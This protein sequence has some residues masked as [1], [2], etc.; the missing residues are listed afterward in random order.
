MPCLLSVISSSMRSSHLLPII[1]RLHLIVLLAASIT[2]TLRADDDTPDSTTN[3]QRPPNIVVIFIDDMGYADIGPFG[4]KDYSTPNLDRMASEGRVFTD[5][6]AATAVCSASRA[7]LLTGC[8]PERIGILG[9]LGPNS[10]HGIN[11]DETTLAEL[12]KS[13][14]YATAIY[15][16][17][18]LGDRP[19]FMPTLHGFD[20]WLGIPYSNDMWPLHPQ[21]AKLSKGAADRKQGYPPLPMY[22]DDHIVDEVITGDEQAQFTKRFTQRAVDFIEHNQKQPFFLYVP[23]PMVHVP[24]FASD[25]FKG[26]S[27]AGLFGDVVMELDWSVGEILN[28]IRKLDLDKNTMVVFTSDNG[29][30]LSYGDHA[31]SAGI[32]REGKGTMFE[33]GYREPC[34]VWWP[35]TIPAGT[36]CDELASTMDLVPTI[37]KL[38]DAKLPDDRTIDGH[39]IWPL[40]SGQPD[41]KS[42][43]EAFYCYYGGQLQA[44]RDRQYKLHFPHQYRSLDGR[45]GGTNGSPVGYKQLKIDLELF[46]LKADPSETTNIAAEHPEIVERL[47]AAGQAA[48]ADLGDSLTKVKGK[49]NRPPGRVKPNKKAP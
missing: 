14:G 41:A 37:A 23:H 19:M 1:V 38:I 45:P 16:K 20:E 10:N 29:P 32:F 26:K 46:D 48:R 7:A 49:N 35:D 27:G 40:L 13:K 36:K 44:I 12:C 8:Y 11:P 34:I 3:A 47:Q 25:D 33:G 24:L 31:G 22:E 39:N 42:P 5:F 2:S 43:Y 30:W 21:Y 9:A 6:H 18:H 15:G 28:T 4:A 17:W